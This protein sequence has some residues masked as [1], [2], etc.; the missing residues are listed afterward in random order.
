MKYLLRIGVFVSGVALAL[1][2]GYFSGYLAALVVPKAYFAFFGREHRTLAWIIVNLVYVALPFFLLSLG[3]C[4]LTLRAATSSIKEAAWF[5]F[6]GIVLGLV[7]EEWMSAIALRA[8]E[9][10][11][12]SS[13]F[14]S[15][16]WRVLP[17]WRDLPNFLAFPAGLVAA[18]ALVRRP[19]R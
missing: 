1:A 8:A 2:A 15:Y 13:S 16:L 18:F 5:C 9:G 14:S 10:L 7:Y 6:G 3:W 17:N 11:P 12:N 4:W 19:L